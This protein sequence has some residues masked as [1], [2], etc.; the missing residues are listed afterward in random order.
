MDDWLTWAAIVLPWGWLVWG[1]ISDRRADKQAAVREAGIAR[2]DCGHILTA[3]EGPENNG[4]CTVELRRERY[5]DSGNRNGWEY[6]Q[7]PCR[8]YRGPRPLERYLSLPPTLE[9]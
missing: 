2:C 7:C 8:N 6:A 3:H 9:D 1:R 4:R 5:E